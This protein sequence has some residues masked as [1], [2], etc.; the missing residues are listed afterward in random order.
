MIV[1]NVGGL[2]K[3]VP[4]DKAG[5]VAEP[6]AV[7]LAQK[8]DEYFAKGTAYFIPQLLEEKKKL[9]WVKMTESILELAGSIK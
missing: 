9:S 3:L 7:S 2:P 1:T 5:L 8:I 4:D 6:T